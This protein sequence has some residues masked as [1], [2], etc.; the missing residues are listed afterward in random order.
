MPGESELFLALRAGDVDAIRRAIEAEPGRALCRDSSGTSL[1][2]TALYHRQFG[3]VEFLLERVGTIDCFEAAALG[4]T[5]D[6]V[7]AAGRSHSVIT[8]RSSDGFTVLHLASYFGH[9]DTVQW[10]LR[11][12]APVDAVAANPSLVRPLH[13]AVAA[14][15]ARIAML[16]LD[17]GAE[18]NAP[19]HGGFTPL[20]A[21]AHRGDADLVDLLLARGGDPRCAC[22]DGRKPTDFARDAGHAAIA[23]RLSKT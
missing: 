4:R 12:G 3:L 2:M 13:S 5:Y 8:N 7:S 15:S 18:P 9:V 21:A 6:L 20:H 14:G 22:D 17:A 19:Q 16:L 23:A 11:H 1:L 10:L